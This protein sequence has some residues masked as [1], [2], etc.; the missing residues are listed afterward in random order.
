MAKVRVL[1]QEGQPPSLLTRLRYLSEELRLHESLFALPFAYTGMLMAARGLPT[2]HQF[3]WITL[4]MIGA[5]N[6]GMGMNRV[7]DK[8]I[9]AVN[10]RTRE[11]H[12]PAGRTRVWE[13][14]AVSG[15]ALAIFLV[16]AWQLN[17]M[18][19]A[20]AWIAAAY[21]VFYSYTKR[22]SWASNLALGWALAIGPAG[23]WIGVTGH[24]SWNMLLLASVVFFWASAF[25]ILHHMPS[26]DFYI[27]HGLH[28]VVQRFGLKT[29][30]M[31]ARVHDAL[32]VLALIALGLTL[33][34][35]APYYVGIA[36]AATILIRKHTLVSPSDL[37]RL[38]VAFFL[39]NAV[40][41]AIILV[42]T[43]VTLVW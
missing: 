18:A 6:F 15:L 40:F 1:R 17:P 22:F 14:L 36:I 2:L 28:S 25:D 35:D 9:D 19:F 10:P 24:L 26:R 43:F 30:L 7:I 32:A 4:A 8:G 37:S 13:M 41:S 3:I 42:A 23:G 11:R 38:G 21:L 27:Q 31:W 34:L 5:R 29:A 16:A 12:I 39:Y 20:L 33:K